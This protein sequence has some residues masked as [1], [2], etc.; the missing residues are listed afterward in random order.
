MTQHTVKDSL[1][2]CPHCPYMQSLAVSVL[3][4]ILKIEEKAFVKIF[5]GF[6]FFAIRACSGQLRVESCAHLASYSSHALS[7]S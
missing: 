2:T 1:K 4:E 3:H 7:A 6:L 5:P